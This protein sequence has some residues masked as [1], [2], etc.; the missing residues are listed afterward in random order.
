[1]CTANNLN[2]GLF[3]MGEVGSPITFRKANVHPAS[4]LSYLGA[5]IPVVSSSG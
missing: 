4:M 2:L 1:M 5:V 3:L